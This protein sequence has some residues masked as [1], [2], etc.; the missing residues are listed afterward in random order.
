MVETTANA[1]GEDL[2][3]DLLLSF[4]TTKLKHITAERDELAASVSRV[5]S[6]HTRTTGWCEECD[7]RQPCPT[8]KALRGGSH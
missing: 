7:Q 8:L 6:L 4:K 3:Y 1:P 2:A 5:V